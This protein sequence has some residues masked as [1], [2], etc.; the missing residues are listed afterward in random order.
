MLCIRFVSRA[1][2]VPVAVAYGLD[3]RGT[4][5]RF[6]AEARDI[7]YS[8]ASRPPLGPT[9]PP[10]QWVLE[11]LTP[12]VKRRGREADHSPAFSAAVKDGGPIPTL[13][14]KSSWSNA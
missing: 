8:T 4:G 14:H 13:P 9:Q 1:S 5:V 12:R 2:S 3:N 7:F 10:I 6:S 11:A